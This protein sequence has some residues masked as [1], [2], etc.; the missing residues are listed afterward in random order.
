LW[1]FGY[2]S[3]CKILKRPGHDFL[4]EPLSSSSHCLSWPLLQG[5]MWLCW[6]SQLWEK[7]ILVLGHPLHPAL[8]WV[9]IGTRTKVPKRFVTYLSKVVKINKKCFDQVIPSQ[10]VKTFWVM[11]YIEVQN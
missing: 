2:K 4:Y 10:L 3:G 8:G 5:Q 1:N 6:I 9:D 7:H 11:H